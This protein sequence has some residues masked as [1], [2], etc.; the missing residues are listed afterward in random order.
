MNRQQLI[1]E[2]IKLLDSGVPVSTLPGELVK[3]FG[4]SPAAAQSA[5]QVA[6]RK[7]QQ[8]KRGDR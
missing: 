6:L 4:V 7:R 3:H 2:A 5:T 1:D 8:R